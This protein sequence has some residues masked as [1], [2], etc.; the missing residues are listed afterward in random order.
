MATRCVNITKLYYLNDWC[1]MGDDM[2]DLEHYHGWNGI[3]I[4]ALLGE[5]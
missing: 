5:A 4:V 3:G 2:E 1:G